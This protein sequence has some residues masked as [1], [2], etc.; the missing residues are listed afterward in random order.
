MSDHQNVRIFATQ[1]FEGGLISNYP[2]HALEGDASPDTENFDPTAAWRLKKRAGTSN[3]SG[4]HASPTGTKVR[5]LGAF[6]FEDGTNKIL[7]KEGTALNDIT[8]GN[9]STVLASYTPADGTE[10]FLTMFK[11]VIVIT[12]SA[13]VAP[14]TWSGSGATAALSGSPPSAAY[15]VLHKNRLYLFSTSADPSRFYFSALNTHTDWSTADNSGNDYVNPGDGMVLNGAASDGEHLYFSKKAVS[16]YEG[17]I[18]VL[19]G[20]GPTDFALKRACFFGAVGP[21]CLITTPHFVAFASNKGIYG[22]NG[23]DLILLSDAVDDQWLGL[24]DAQ[25]AEACMGYYGDQLWVAYPDTGST[26]TKVLVLDVIT[27]KWNRYNFP[28]NVAPRILATNQDG[29]LYGAGPS[30]T[31]RVLKYNTGLTD[32]GSTAIASY[33]WLPDIDFGSWF[34]DKQIKGFRLHVKNQA[35]TWTVTHKLDG[36]DSGDSA[37]MVGSTEGPVKRFAGRTAE[38]RSRFIQFKIAEASTTLVSE[39][40]GFECDAELFPRTN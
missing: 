33:W 8:A 23:R 38:T 11:N 34:T 22:L 10:T 12:D 2:Q 17:A 29:V 37:T 36:T 39:L 30:S 20:S 13:Y 32:V 6:T 24:T 25:R 16:T 4:D 19:Y 28:A 7:A 1:G 35:T 27:K 15:S 40:Y 31:I 5:G 9:W 18:F 14:R 3:F 26:N 21:R